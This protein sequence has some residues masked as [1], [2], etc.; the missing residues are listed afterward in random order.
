MIRSLIPLIGFKYTSLSVALIVFVTLGISNVVLKQPTAP[1]AKRDFLDRSALTDVPYVLFVIGCVLTFLGLYTTFF[2]IATY[3]VEANITSQST[4]LYLV[5]ILNGASVFGRVLPNMPAL[6]LRLGPLNMIVVSVLSMAIIVL[7]FNAGPN[8]AGLVVMVIFYGFFVGA[9]FTL[10]PTIFERLTEDKSRYG[11]RL[12]MASTVSSF[13]LL[14]GAPAA[15]ALM[16][17]YGFFASWAWSGI[18]L[19]LGA[20]AMA[21]SRGS[22]SK[23]RLSV[24]V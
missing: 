13:G 24:S 21:A 15:G 6:T 8:L 22:V 17:T 19:A 9:F 23:W 7:L 18:S 20:A 14:L 5:S 3:A 2:Y 4:A 10:Q 11:T 12:G 16:R 1:R